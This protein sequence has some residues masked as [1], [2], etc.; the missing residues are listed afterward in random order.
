MQ[1]A[2][3]REA[4]SRSRLVA[5]GSFCA[6][7]W[8]CIASC[9]DPAPARM[10]DASLDDARRGRR[11]AGE[12]DEPPPPRDG[13]VPEP[14]AEAE[15]GPPADPEPEPLDAGCALDPPLAWPDAVPGSPDWG[16]DTPV[17]L[18]GR[19]NPYAL[20]GETLITRVRAG[21]RHAL[22]YPVDVGNAWLPLGLMERILAAPPDEGLIGELINLLNP[23]SRFDTLDEFEAW[24]GLVPFPDCDGLGAQSVP[25]PDGQR[26]SYRMGSTRAPTRHGEALSYG[27]AGCHAG[28][29][30][31]R[32][33]LGLQNRL[34]RA[35][36]GV[37]RGRAAIQLAGPE[38]VADSFA[39]SDEERAMLIELNDAMSFIAGREP[40]VR[41]L[42]TS[43]AQVALSLA[44]RGQDPYA[45]LDPTAAASPRPDPLDDFPADSKP[46]N[47]WVLKYKNRWLL[48]G[49]V[50]SGNPVFT[51]ILWNEIGRGTD[52]R[53]LQ[54]WLEVNAALLDELT[55]AV[56]AAQPPRITDFFPAERID[57]EGAKRG[58][59]LFDR[60]CARCHGSYDKAWE[61]P[62]AEALPR[63]AQLATI[64]LSYHE[65]T[66]VVDVGT[67]ALRYLGMSSL[68]QLNAL[69]ISKQLGARVVPQVGYVP[70]PLVGIWARFPYFHNNAAPSLCAVL[71]RAE[72]R[73]ARY[74]AGEPLDPE[75]DFD[76]ACNGYPLGNDVPS[77]WRADPEA[78]YDTILPG[79]WNT[80]H[81]EGIFLLD[82]VELLR[83]SDKRDL[84]SFL[85]TL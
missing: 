14:P 6:L 23:L 27:C 61:Q 84:I 57:L 83:E 9:A 3:P 67:D 10:L 59:P 7:A 35:N 15:A 63:A 78:L 45:T 19:P 72:E 70:P 48:D 22:A 40:L 54:S 71:T 41:G 77:A 39:A 68:E 33:L 8:L 26:P 49:S 36:V 11:D 42:D 43:L 47:W 51:N 46:G 30:F 25:F 16:E 69:A 1:Y 74:Y 31:G 76:F 56:F 50:V 20:S 24:L 82:G 2:E 38:L 4:P 28:R 53:V 64:A 37:E 65:R 32:S 5:G 44:K 85:Q 60:H 17:P 13:Q 29:L 18:G 55:A 73:P 75:H 52:L 66:P 79:L 34:S 80:G 58:K 62:G 81:D 12:L 21:Q